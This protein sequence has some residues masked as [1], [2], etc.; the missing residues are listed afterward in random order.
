MILARLATINSAMSKEKKM[1]GSIY[2]KTLMIDFI[3]VSIQ[4]K[5]PRTESDIAW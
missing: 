2:I 1:L 5:I 4:Q 3:K